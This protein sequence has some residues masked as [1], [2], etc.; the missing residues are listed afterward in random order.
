MYIS[1]GSIATET[2]LSGGVVTINKDAVASN[3]TVS[4]G[5]FQVSSGVANGVLL[6]GDQAYLYV[7]L[8]GCA[9]DVTV[10]DGNVSVSSGTI[11][12]MKVNKGKTVHIYGAGIVNSAELN[13]NAMI[14]VS[15]GG[16]ASS[17]IVNS[18]GQVY[19]YGNGVAKDT[20]V[21]S[22]GLIAVSAGGNATNII[23]NAGGYLGGFAFAEDK[24]IDQIT[25]GTFAVA[26]NAVITGKVMNIT[27]GGEVSD[28][29]VGVSVP[30]ASPMA[31][32]Q[33]APQWFP[34][35]PYSFPTVVL[36][37]VPP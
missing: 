20:T 25:D 23:L 15:S 6:T 30:C 27:E 4:S 8:N 10:D 3:T 22:G 14:N 19:V 31:V 9:N 18:T 32:L 24:E 13:N 5:W 26:D 36:P 29:T 11:N 7:T 35:V 37:P 21:S 2:T 17:T 28:I 34:A 16:T 33:T 1:S 12:R